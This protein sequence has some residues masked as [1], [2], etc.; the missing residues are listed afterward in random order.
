MK[1]KQEM[2][3]L[4]WEHSV[5]DHRN[6]L[7]YGKQWSLSKLILIRYKITLRIIIEKNILRL[8]CELQWSSQKQKNFPATC[9]RKRSQYIFNI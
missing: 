9:L 8:V 1:I 3:I 7:E 4:Y 5:Y 6:K 2:S